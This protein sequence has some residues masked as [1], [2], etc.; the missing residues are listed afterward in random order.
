M[1]LSQITLENV[2]NFAE[3]LFPTTEIQLPDHDAWPPAK[4]AL[5]AI[6]LAHSRTKSSYEQITVSLS[7]SSPPSHDQPH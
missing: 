5:R 2:D 4:K 7:T 3:S 1:A 6:T